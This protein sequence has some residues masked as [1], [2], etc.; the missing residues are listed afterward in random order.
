MVRR[1]FCPLFNF[2]DILNKFKG[3][4][5][6]VRKVYYV[7]PLTRDGKLDWRVKLENAKKANEIYKDKSDAL[8]QAT[9]L[10]KNAGLGQV[11]IQGRDGKFQKEFTYGQDPEKYK[12]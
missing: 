8:R 11:K 1:I 7:S 9:R 4:K 6:A 5:M 2:L 10:A 3:D 12:G